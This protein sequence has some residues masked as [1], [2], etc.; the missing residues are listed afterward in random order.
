MTRLGMRH[1]SIQQD[2]V[3]S[4]IK[5]NDPAFL[6]ATTAGNWEIKLLMRPAESPDTNLLDLSCF[7]ALQRPSQ[8]D[9]GFANEIN[10]FI[11]QVTRS[12]HDF[13]PRQVNFGFLT[14]QACP[15]QI[16]ISNGGNTYSPRRCECGNR[17]NRRERVEM[18]RVSTTW[19]IPVHTWHNKV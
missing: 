16:L 19:N 7:R 5:Q 15:D 18:G 6:A 4:H 12:Y 8:W 1:N 14:L 9:H 10:G 13:S 2:G 3:S 17:R 11:A